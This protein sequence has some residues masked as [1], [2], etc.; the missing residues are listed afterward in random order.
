[1]KISASLFWCIQLKLE[2]QKCQTLSGF[3]ALKCHDRMSSSVIYEAEQ[4]L[5]VLDGWLDKKKTLTLG[6]G[7]L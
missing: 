6:S 7:Y 5:L 3:R 1:M 2:L 4:I